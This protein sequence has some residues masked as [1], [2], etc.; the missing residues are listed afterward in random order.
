MRAAPGISCKVVL[1]TCVPWLA[2]RQTHAAD[3]AFSRRRKP[4]MLHARRSLPLCLSLAL[5]LA[6]NPGGPAG[7]ATGAAG[8]AT[9]GAAGPDGK[10]EALPGVTAPVVDPVAELTAVHGPAGVRTEDLAEGTFLGAGARL[11]A[12]QVL[13]VPRGTMAELKLMDGTLLRINEDSRVTAP[14]G[15]QGRALELGSGELVAIVAAGQ[16]P[17]TVKSGADVLEISSGEAHALAR[18]ERRSYDV[19]YGAATL[20]SGGQQVALTPGAHVET[21]LAAPG[22]PG[23]QPGG[24]PVQPEISLRPL[25]DTAWSRTFEIAA[26]M[27]DAVP[28]GVGSLTARRAGTQTELH[29]LALTSQQVNVSISGRIARTEIEQTFYNEAG[30]VLEGTY[31]FPL[32]ADASISGL[33]LLVGNTWMNAEMLEKERAREIFRQ[34]VDATIPRD[35][36]LLEWEKGNIFKMKIFPIP[37]RGERKIRLSYTQ[38]LPVVGDTLRYR[39]PIAGSSSGATGEEIG[40][41]GFTVAV[42]KAAL[43]ADGLASIATPMAQLDRRELPDRVE[44]S[45]HKQRFRPVHDLGVDIPLTASEQRQHAETHLDR[46]GQAY[47]MLAVKP[48][49]KLPASDRPVHYAFVMD[50]SHSMTPELWTVARSVV[51]A[52]STS[53]GADDRMT[54]LACDS[55]CDAAP[56]GLAAAAQA[57]PGVDA[58]LDQQILAGAS[59]LGGMMR[60]AAEALNGADAGIN[61]AGPNAPE[62]V[63]VYLG[64]GN[65]SAGELAPDELLRHLEQPLA[66]TRVQA[67]ALG[68]RSDLLFLDALTRRTGGDLLRADAKDDLRGLVRELRLRAEVP[69][70]RDVQLTLPRGMEYV[71]PQRVSALRPGDTVLLT[72]KLSQP[73][74]GALDLRATSPS[75]QVLSDSFQVDLEAAPNAQGSTHTHLPRTW[76]RFEIDELTASKGHAAR[77]EIIDLS[78]QYTVL[79]RYTALLVLENDAMF[80]EFN[81]VRQAGKTTGWNGQL[82]GPTPPTTTTPTTTGTIAAPEPAKDPAPASG[83][84][85]PAA[86]PSPAPPSPPAAS[87]PKPVEL[88]DPYDSAAEKA[89]ARD[90]K[91][92]ENKIADRD[93]P[94]EEQAKSRSQGEAEE[95]PADKNNRDDDVLGLDNATTESSSPTPAPKA[96]KESTSP[97]TKPSPMKRADSGDDWG[98]GLGGGYGGPPGRVARYQP[99]WKVAQ[100]GPP[101][102][103]ALAKLETLRQAVLR[104]PTSR[105]AH[106]KLVHNAIRAGAPEAFTYATAWSQADPDHAAALLAVADLL[107]ARSDPAALRAYGSA[108]EV[109]PFNLK[110]QTRLAEAYAS[111]GDITRSCAHRRA[112]VSIDPA[113]PDNHL[114]LARCLSTLGRQDLVRDAVTDALGRAK[115]NTAELRAA[116]S[117]VVRPAKPRGINGMVKAS[118]TWT[119]AGDLDLAFIDGRGRR[120]SALRPEGLSVEEQGN[121]EN[122]ALASMPRGTVSVEVTR[123]NGQGPVTGELKV[124]T[125]EVTRTYPFT[126]DQGTL[127]LANITNLGW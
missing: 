87:A 31:R 39:Y 70:A 24:A 69:V 117:G 126:I 108:V 12:G 33:S 88:P 79:S 53:L 22:Q 99:L 41:F 97:T 35:P 107:A 84:S 64:D 25:E 36:A 103:S 124:R 93:M 14:D 73:V 65:P 101:D 5:V 92:A 47:F 52:M 30:E 45:T 17:L 7:S 18:G 59:D 8:S 63:I 16:S 21:P 56:G 15:P 86:E 71:H 6:C 61:T 62:R 27:A 54:V 11:R 46:D 9:A 96:K 1:P 127:R 72:G 57:M 13:V 80:R 89:P 49:L 125:P 98:E 81:V 55:A 105:P 112:V 115:G 122:A 74:H 19:V 2:S 76:A 116:Q 110:Q 29:K 91:A 38:V 102:Y 66:A 3:E 104:D 50:R 23:S 77:T 123:F 121:A 82:A 10:T 119:G 28:P 118:L 75:G 4:P 120:L 26:A 114:Q 78:R 67:V 106:R 113:R 34:I 60:S 37:G 94:R 85:R 90:S 40:D 51:Q 95:E 20:R 42:D 68:A 109:N 100:A 32:P 83:A 44:L 43:P 58:F 111:K 48:D